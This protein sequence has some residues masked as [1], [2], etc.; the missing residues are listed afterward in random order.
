MPHGSLTDKESITFKIYHIISTAFCVIVII[1]NTISPKMAL[2][3]FFQDFSVPAGLLTYPLTFFL[4]DL[5]AE[6]YGAKRAKQMVYLAFGMSILSFL[7]IRIALLVPSPTAE[8][9][10]QFQDVFGLNGTILFASLTAYIMAQTLDIKIYAIIKIWTGESHLWVRNNGSTLIAQLIDTAIVNLIHLY[11]GMGMEI[12]QVISIMLFSY[13]YK[14]TLS[15]AL[16]PFFYFTVSLFRRA[17]LRV[18][19]PS[20]GKIR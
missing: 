12:S 20:S 13:I 14:C 8:N 2:L 19:P 5:V 3:P 18:V 16:T 6:I 9:H 10:K 15:I 11:L 17:N 4:S 7:M 1:S